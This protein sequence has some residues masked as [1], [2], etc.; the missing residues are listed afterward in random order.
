MF[1]RRGAGCDDKTQGVLQQ[2][3]SAIYCVIEFH[4]I[5][6]SLFIGYT[7]LLNEYSFYGFFLLLCVLNEYQSI[8]AF[9]FIRSLIYPA[10]LT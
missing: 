7:Y 8:I 3:R 2:N 4:R 1:V 5:G 6:L 9:S 10:D